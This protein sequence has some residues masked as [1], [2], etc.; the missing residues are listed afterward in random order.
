MM[1][2][3]EKARKRREFDREAERITGYKLN[4]MSPPPDDVL[5]FFDT[6][7]KAREHGLSIGEAERAAST[8][9]RQVS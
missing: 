3:F 1:K 2:F 8:K 9:L 5:R 4:P 7:G 6:Y